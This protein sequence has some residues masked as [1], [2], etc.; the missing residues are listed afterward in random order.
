MK[1]V[2]QRKRMTQGPPLTP[3]CRMKEGREKKAP[4]LSRSV[5]DQ[6]SEDTCEEEK[7][8]R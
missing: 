6:K 1:E 8:I 2:N 7:K 3:K 5:K 4:E